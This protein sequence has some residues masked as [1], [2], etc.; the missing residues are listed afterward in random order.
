MEDRKSNKK[1][2]KTTVKRTTDTPRGRRRFSEQEVMNLIEG[3]R[4]F[5]RDWRK[6]LSNYDFEDRNN[7]DLKD[8]ARNLDK[9]GLI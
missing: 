5:G 1:I 9:L 2:R 3:I 6:I 8:K 7:V 4:R